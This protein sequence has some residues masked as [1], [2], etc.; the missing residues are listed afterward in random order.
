MTFE[1]HDDGSIMITG[2]DDIQAYRM[3]S[4]IKALEVEV[5]TGMRMS[6]KFNLL[7]SLR[8]EYS[9]NS[10]KKVDAI[11]ELKNLFHQRFE[12]YPFKD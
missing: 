8:E 12:T 6:S 5:R 10:R 3:L 9:L 7:K 11:E 2:E 4:Q 1:K